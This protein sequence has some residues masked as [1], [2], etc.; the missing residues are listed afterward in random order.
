MFSRKV[1]DNLYNDKQLFGGADEADADAGDLGGDD[2]GTD[3]VGTTE[4]GPAFAIPGL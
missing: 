4:G 1:F 3:N 2:T